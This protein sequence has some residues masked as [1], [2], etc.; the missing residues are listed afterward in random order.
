V[1]QAYLSVVAYVDALP[2]IRTLAA[3]D[4]ALALASRKHE[5]IIV[6]SYLGDSHLELD[7]T[8]FSGPVT[9]VATHPRA[10]RDA[11][12]L[13]GLARSVGDFVI[14]WHADIARLDVV[15]L[16]ALLEPSDHGVELIEVAGDE[17]SRISRTFYRVVNSLRPR[18]LPVTKVIARV[19]SRHAL[20]QVLAATSFEPQLN[21]LAAELPVQRRTIRIAAVPANPLTTRERVS[22]GLALLSKGTRFGSA[23]PL[24]L[25][26]ASTAFGI[27]AAAW[28][29]GFF[30]I[31]GRTPEGWTTL[32]VVIGLGQAAILA[33]LGLTWTRID[34]LT[35]GLSRNHDATANVFTWAPGNEQVSGQA[36]SGASE[37]RPLRT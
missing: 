18:D 7:P 8:E 1:K 6:V 32:M 13:A 19:Y 12:T 17:G 4:E 20:G 36:E 35:R 24:A 10:T 22:E 37:R 27:A 25:A 29:L 2:S 16:A 34:S 5:I 14:E 3:V 28:A 31:R 11:A 26:A 23:I 33:M 30:I 21:I 9:I 15:T